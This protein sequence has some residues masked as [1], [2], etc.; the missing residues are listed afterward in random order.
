MCRNEVAQKCPA[1]FISD[2]FVDQLFCTVKKLT[3]SSVPPANEVWG[4]VMFLQLSVIL[5]TGRGG[6]GGSILEG[7]KGVS[8]PG[9][10][11][12]GR[13]SAGKTRRTV[14]SEWYASY[15]NA[16]LLF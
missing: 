13:V 1:Y 8:V 3:T 10:L 6:L 9:G 16:F 12:L 5:F 7:G 4:K 14:K 2:L 15:W 11:F